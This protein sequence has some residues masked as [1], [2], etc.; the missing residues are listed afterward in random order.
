MSASTHSSDSGNQLSQG[1]PGTDLRDVRA[2]NA[3]RICDD[4]ERVDNGRGRETHPLTVSA[5]MAVPHPG[6][7][8]YQLEPRQEHRISG[9]TKIIEAA[10]TIAPMGHISQQLA[11]R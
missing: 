2:A 10:A 1:V 4:A 5:D 7:R 8:P 11:E 9:A 6:R 3:A